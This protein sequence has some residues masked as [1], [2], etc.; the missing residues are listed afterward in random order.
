MMYRKDYRA[1]AEIINRVQRDHPGSWPLVRDLIEGFASMLKAD[2]PRFDRD[3]FRAACI[4]G[5]Q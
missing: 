2:N 4:N 5:D 3:R 1:I